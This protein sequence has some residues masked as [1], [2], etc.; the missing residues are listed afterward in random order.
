M[1]AVWFFSGENA[2]DCLEEKAAKWVSVLLGKKPGVFPNSPIFVS[3][4]VLLREK[5]EYKREVPPCPFPPHAATFALSPRSVPRALSKKC[6]EGKAGR[7]AMQLLTKKNVCS[8]AALNC[9]EKAPLPAPLCQLSSLLLFPS[10]FFFFF[11]QE[12]RSEEP[13][14][15]DFFFI[16]LHYSKMNAFF[17]ISAHVFT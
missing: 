13:E 4:P 6:R 5:E 11:S 7:G 15:R 9:P 16:V 1:W 17:Q 12:G 14:R 8:A 3:P 10:F 2:G